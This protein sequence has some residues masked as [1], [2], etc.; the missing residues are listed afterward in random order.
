MTRARLADLACLA[1]A[2]ALVAIP[3]AVIFIAAGAQGA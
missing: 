3:F 1:A 2:C